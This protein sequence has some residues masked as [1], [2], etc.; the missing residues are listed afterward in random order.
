MVVSKVFDNQPEPT[1]PTN[2][3]YNV[4][5][6]RVEREM[7]GKE[8]EHMV[9]DRRVFADKVVKNAMKRHPKKEL[10]A[11]G[12]AGSVRLVHRFL[13]NRVWVWA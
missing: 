2:S 9:M 1:L 7:S 8:L 10:W 6:A 3:L 4:S 12:H 11:G 5:K 13:G